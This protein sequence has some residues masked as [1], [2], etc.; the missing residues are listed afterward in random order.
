MIERLLQR[1]RPTE[2]D[3]FDLARRETDPRL[4]KHFEPIARGPAFAVAALVALGIVA[5]CT[6]PFRLVLRRR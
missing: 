5:A 4:L 2:R 6:V 3:V 1:L